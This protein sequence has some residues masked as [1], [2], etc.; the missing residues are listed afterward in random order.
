LRGGFLMV[1]DFHAN[2]EW[3]V[4]MRGM[5]QVFP[6]RS[7]V[8]IPNDDPIFHVLYDMNDRV[9]I[10]G[11]QFVESGRTYE[12]DESGRPEHWRA[13]YDDKGRVMVAI[14]HNM[15]LGDAV[16]HSDD[17]EYPEKYA[18]LAYRVY[19]NYFV[20]DLTH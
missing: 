6:D 3:E 9:Q 11:Y 1:D 2:Q 12:K 8:D 19:I 14:C 10:P 7:W 4:F 18:G 15:D 13:I 5:S 17:P 20:Y 16:E